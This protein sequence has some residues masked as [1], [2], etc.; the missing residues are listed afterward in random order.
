MA[1]NPFS[2]I[3]EALYKPKLNAVGVD[4]QG[5]YVD[6]QGKPTSLYTQPGF[7]ER[8]LNPEAQQIQLLNAQASADPQ[9]ALQSRAIARNLG[10]LDYS[11][12]TPAEQAAAG[13]NPANAQTLTGGDYRA[14]NLTGVQGSV[15]DINNGVPGAQ[16][17]L[18]LNSSLAGAQEAKNNLTQSALAGLLGTPSTAAMGQNV[19]QNN[20]LDMATG[21][22]AIIPQQLMNQGLQT[23]NETQQLQG[24]RAALPNENADLFNRAKIAMATSGQGVQDLP[25][26]LGTQRAQ[27][28]TGLYGAENP[29]VPYSPFAAHVDTGAGTITPGRYATPGMQSAAAMGINLQGG[30]SAPRT[31]TINGKT[32]AL[33][34]AGTGMPSPSLNTGNQPLPSGSGQDWSAGAANVPL[35][36]DEG[37]TK[38]NAFDEVEQPQVVGRGQPYSRATGVNG[39]QHI[40]QQHLSNAVEQQ[41]KVLKGVAKQYGTQSPHYREAYQDYVDMVNT[42]PK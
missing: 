38:Q 41:Q 30:A 24:T 9:R 6:A 10:G 42:L 2:A 32:I 1:D 16:S 22:R 21:Q 35:S 27:D 13:I 40:A 8:A 23:G 18:R 12:L 36:E 7:F 37:I 25:Q 39:L 29:N 15:A 34:G 4:A 17:A 14:Q 26:T 19:D 20:Q 28:I 3:A 31:V 5:N 11:T 33:P